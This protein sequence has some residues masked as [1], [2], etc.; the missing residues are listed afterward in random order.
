[1]P[2]DNQI[3]DKGPEANGPEVEQLLADLAGGQLAFDDPLAIAAFETHPGLEERARDFVD[4]SAMVKASFAEERE[5]LGRADAITD[6]SLEEQVQLAA[7]RADGHG[8]DWHGADGHGGGGARHR[9]DRPSKP[10][11]AQ[12]SRRLALLVGAAAAASLFVVLFL[13]KD[14]PQRDGLGTDTDLGA[15]D[16][17]IVSPA[18]TTWTG[19]EVAWTCR[20]EWAKNY[21]VIVVPEDDE[22]AP[23]RSSVIGGTR[24]ELTDAEAER[25]PDSGTV[26]I[27]VRTVSEIAIGA[28]KTVELLPRD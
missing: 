14:E 22:L 4:V 6:P 16:L 26:T 9:A 13:R 15:G 8:A 28:Q 10:Y 7:D 1:M 25:L 23:L 21:E 11:D 27:T 18:S 12:R 5:V 19:D 2:D 3:G 17:T 24:W 20:L